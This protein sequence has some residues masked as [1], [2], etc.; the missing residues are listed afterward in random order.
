MT[1]EYKQW[2]DS[3]KIGD[4][5]YCTWG[6]RIEKVTHITKTRQIDVG[7]HRYKNGEHTIKE[8]RYGTTHHI[9][10]VTQEVLD[11]IEQRELASE[12][13]SKLYGNAIFSL[14][15]NKLKA[16]KQILEEK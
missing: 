6:G 5:V 3:L 9:K 16:I 14:P 4:E 13:H 2:L 1:D 7:S 11:K 10:P 15:L 8:S 12:V